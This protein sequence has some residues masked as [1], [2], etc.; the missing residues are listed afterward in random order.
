MC[1]CV[2]VFE[3]EIGCVDVT[4]CV[5]ERERWC[6][7]RR[8]SSRKRDGLSVCFIERVSEREKWCD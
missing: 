7:L 1:V 8:A 3:S 2:C 5:S 6:L 4:Q